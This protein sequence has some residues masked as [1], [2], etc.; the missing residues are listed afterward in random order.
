[1]NGEQKL[2]C[3]LAGYTAIRSTLFDGRR[4]THFRLLG[5]LGLHCMCPGVFLRS[6]VK[7]LCIPNYFG[8]WAF[9]VGYRE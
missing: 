4:S 3:L 6:V 1:M 2:L 5:F 8:G 9:R 7:T